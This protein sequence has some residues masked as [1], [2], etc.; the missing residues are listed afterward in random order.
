M[1][2][3]LYELLFHYDVASASTLNFF[4][5]TILDTMGYQLK[6]ISVNLVLPKKLKINFRELYKVFILQHKS[7][8][9]I[10]IYFQWAL[11][12]QFIVSTLRYVSLINTKRI[13]GYQMPHLICYNFVKVVWM[14]ESCEGFLNEVRV[15][16]L[17]DH[18]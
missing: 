17:M 8:D 15:S 4:F 10:M 14:L 2:K 13:D 16:F 11:S 1:H 18:K 7:I 5:V 12:S 6:V 3:S 9:Y